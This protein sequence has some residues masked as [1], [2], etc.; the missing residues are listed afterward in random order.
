[1][2]GEA[3]PI[4]TLASAEDLALRREARARI[5]SVVMG[6][7]PHAQQQQQ[8]EEEDEEE[9]EGALFAGYARGVWESVRNEEDAIL[10][11]LVATSGPTAARPST[12]LLPSGG[13]EEEVEDGEEDGEEDL[14]ARLVREVGQERADAAAFEEQLQA[15]Q[16]L[17]ATAAASHVGH[18]LVI[19]AAPLCAVPMP[20]LLRPRTCAAA[21]GTAFAAA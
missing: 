19:A 9:E 7:G 16:H 10:A 15:A 20:V 18:A 2:G 5:A 17:G 1:M 14:L 13:E 12:S 6:G 21:R 8:E 4:A 11:A 3:L